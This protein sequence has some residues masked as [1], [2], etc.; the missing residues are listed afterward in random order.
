MPAEF[1]KTSAGV[2]A[3]AQPVRPIVDFVANSRLLLETIKC[4]IETAD[5]LMHHALHSHCLREPT[6]ISQLARLPLAIDEHPQTALEFA[7]LPVDDGLIEKC[8]LHTHAVPG[9]PVE[10][11]LF[12]VERKR[13]VRISSARWMIAWLPRQAA[14]PTLSPRPRA[15]AS[16]SLCSSKASLRLPCSDRICA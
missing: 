9:T 1:D 4:L 7:L 15:R 14:R 10:L 5:A 6:S 2:V 3:S 13:L 12:P 16:S 8:I 11:L